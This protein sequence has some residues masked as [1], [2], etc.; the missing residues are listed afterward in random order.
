MKGYAGAF[1]ATKVFLEW[2]KVAKTMQ[3]AD[4]SVKTEL[5]K[6]RDNM[7][8]LMKASKRTINMEATN[9]FVKGF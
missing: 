7:V 6:F 2:L 1:K 9:V 5:S 4:S 8:N 3:G